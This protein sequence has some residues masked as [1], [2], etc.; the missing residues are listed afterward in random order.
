[1][2]FKLS[3]SVGWSKIAK[4]ATIARRAPLLAALAVV[5]ACTAAQAD[6]GARPRIVVQLPRGHVS[7]GQAGGRVLRR[8]RVRVESRRA[9]VEPPPVRSVP[10]PPARPSEGS[11]ERCLATIDA[12][13]VPYRFAGVVKGVRTPIE[14]TGPIRGVSLVARAARG[15]IMDC[16]LARA[17]AE[18]APIFQRHGVTGLSYSGTYSYRNVRGTSH[19]SGHAFGLAIDVHGLETRFGSIEVERDYPKDAG[20]WNLARAD[21]AGCIGD[22]PAGASAVVRS[23]ACELRGHHAFH[24]VMSPDDNY[25]HRNH[26]H[27]ESYPSR[28]DELLSSSGDKP[29]V[30]HRGRSHPRHRR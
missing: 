4:I 27:L 9:R 3:K 16:E 23:I 28:S 18:A 8:Q 2:H 24:L 12:W 6:T 22:P 30:V 21:V 14:I 17:L 5:S 25:D 26:L 10:A 15:P 7:I 1:L 29:S 13:G 11:D 20:R 19:L